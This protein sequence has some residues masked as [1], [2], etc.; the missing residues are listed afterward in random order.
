M[1]RHAPSKKRKTDK[2]QKHSMNASLIKPRRRRPDLVR[3]FRSRDKSEPKKSCKN[4]KRKVSLKLDVKRL[5]TL[6]LKETSLTMKALCPN[7]K[8]CNVVRLR[9]LRSAKRKK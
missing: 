5:Q 3:S 4:S 2:Q 1:N 7:I 6:K 8:A 9:T